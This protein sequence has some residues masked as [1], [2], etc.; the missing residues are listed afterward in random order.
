MGSDQASLI[1]SQWKMCWWCERQLTHSNRS[2][3]LLRVQGR[4]RNSWTGKHHHFTHCQFTVSH[5][6]F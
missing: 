3:S 5:L 2:L 6:L 1:S 4:F